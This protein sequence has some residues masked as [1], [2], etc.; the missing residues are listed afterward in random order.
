MVDRGASV[1]A[2]L[3]DGTG[4]AVVLE[5]EG[6]HGLE[7]L[8]KERCGGVGVHV[9]TLHTTILLRA[10]EIRGFG[11]ERHTGE[12]AGSGSLSAVSAGRL[13]AYL[14][15]REKDMMKQ[16]VVAIALMGCCVTGIQAQA[17]AASAKAAMEPSKSFDGVLT[18]FEGQF[19][20]VAKAM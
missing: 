2:L 3:M 9:D 19:M 14:A 7:D 6:T 16:M 12:G 1:L 15:E 18:A 13:T 20:G 4:V 11:D 10:D 5:V 8:R 17:P